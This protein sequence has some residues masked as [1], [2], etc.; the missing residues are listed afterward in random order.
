MVRL[1][2]RRPSSTCRSGA[3]INAVCRASNE[4]PL[5]KGTGEFLRRDKANRVDTYS[6]CTLDILLRV[7]DKH[8]LLSGDVKSLQRRQERARLR[9]G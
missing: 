9:L 6:A 8:A 2:A 4:L 5:L 7:V 1:R 3:A